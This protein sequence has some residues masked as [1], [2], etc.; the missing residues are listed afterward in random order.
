MIF[1][2]SMCIKTKQFM[3]TEWSVKYGKEFS[4]VKLN[5][6]PINYYTNCTVKIW[7][8]FSF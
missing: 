6:S 7:P 2:I 5:C 3:F 1:V 8:T 4:D